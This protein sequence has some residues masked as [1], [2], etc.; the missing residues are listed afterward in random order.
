MLSRRSL[1]A[2]T[3]LAL[4]ALGLPR[5]ARAADPASLR[6]LFVFAQGGWDP[7]R[8][9]APE[10]RNDAFD[11]EPDAERAAVGGIAFVDHPSRPSV[12]AFF[13]A[14]HA[15]TT[16]FNG[17]LVRSIAHDICTMIAMTGTTSGTVPDWPA[18][19][20]TGLAGDEALP[21]L[22]LA[23]PSYPGP[24]GASVARTG[25]AGQLDG[26]LNG[27]LLANADLPSG[28]LRSP[29]GAVLDRYLARRAEAAAL[30]G[31]STASRTL[32]GAHRDA[33]RKAARL[34]DLQW[35]LDFGA[36]AALEDQAAVAVE[37][38]SMG[39]S[40]CVTMSAGTAFAWDTHANNDALQAPLWEDLFA[41]LGRLMLMLEETPGTSAPTLAE[42]TLVVVLSELGR[43]PRL[44]GFLGKDHWP[45]TSAMVVG[46]GFSGDRVVGGHDANGYG[47]GVDP[48]SGDSGTSA[49]ALSAEAFGATLLASAGVD[50]GAWVEGASPIEGVLA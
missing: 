19:L 14:H 17:M 44:N 25:T 22:V 8:V 27:S 6:F 50:P 10:F 4:G 47:L 20:G 43:T 15:R 49:P 7:T 13:E 45:Y 46:P 40:R 16:V 48:A 29:S 5:I 41:G 23:G 32:L 26:L 12:S 24:L 21:H 9:F 33:T 1:L 18:I 35:V 3:P 36:S 34:K 42:E 31:R 30:G 38:L 11:M 39:V 2:T 28:R 37:A